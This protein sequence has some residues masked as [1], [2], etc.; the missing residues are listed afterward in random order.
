MMWIITCG[1]A[2]LLGFILFAQF[3]TTAS[4]EFSFLKQK[5]HVAVV[6]PQAVVNTPKPVLPSYT[7]GSRWIVIANGND[8]ELSQDL[9]GKVVVNGMPYDNPTLTVTCYQSKLFIRINSHAALMGKET[10]LI[11]ID[12]TESTWSNQGSFNYY[13]PD[14]KQAI[15]TL[16]SAGRHTVT[17]K[18]V[19]AGTTALHIEGKELKE[20]LKQFSGACQ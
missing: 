6:S 10:S 1:I 3:Q 15:N 18:F 2:A 4:D 19:E 7:V 11:A 16:N 12:G 20:A 13:A 5:P 17:L 8:K 14:S 9:E